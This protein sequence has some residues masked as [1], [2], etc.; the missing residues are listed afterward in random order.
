[1]QPTDYAGIVPKSLLKTLRS[2]PVIRL[3]SKKRIHNKWD[4]PARI[5]A[6]PAPMENAQ[7]DRSGITRSNERHSLNSLRSGLPQV[8]R[9]TEVL[10]EHQQ[11][12][13]E[14]KW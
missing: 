12:R 7:T 10:R 3:P 9:K 4:E 2:A 14:R 8:N 11:P 1:M 6:I 5:C 13:G